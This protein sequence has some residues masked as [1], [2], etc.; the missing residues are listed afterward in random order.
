MFILKSKYKEIS[1]KLEYKTKSVQELVEKNIK[2]ENELK[3]AKDLKELLT[4][5]VERT[6]IPAFKP[7]GGKTGGYL[8]VTDYGYGAVTGT[9][10]N[11]T[12]LPDS[13][14]QYVDD[15]FGGKV[16]K[17]EAHIGIKVSKDGK[18]TTGLTKKKKD[19]GYNY[20]LVRE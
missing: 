2:L 19:K 15:I 5:I 13:V 17:Q 9:F 6:G 14:L 18:V 7:E 12:N 20:T 10:H 11:E 3:E 8:Y 16:I 4:K 1:N